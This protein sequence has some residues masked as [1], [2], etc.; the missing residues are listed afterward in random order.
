MQVEK[1]AGE[2]IRKKSRIDLVAVA[3][4]SRALV[5]LSTA[6]GK[7]AKDVFRDRR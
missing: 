5:K 7:R 1:L 3:Y 4:A 2:K 6:G